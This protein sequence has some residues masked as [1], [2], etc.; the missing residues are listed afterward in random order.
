M[1]KLNNELSREIPDWAIECSLAVD[2]VGVLGTNNVDYFLE[3]ISKPPQLS[4]ELMGQ[5]HHRSS[6]YD[7]SPKVLRSTCVG[8]NCFCLQQRQWNRQIFT[9]VKNNYGQCDWWLKSSASTVS[10]NLQSTKLELAEDE[11]L[12]ICV[13]ENHSF[14]DKVQILDLWSKIICYQTQ[15]EYQTMMWPW[16]SR[17]KEALTSV[18][19]SFNSSL[20]KDTHRIGGGGSCYSCWRFPVCHGGLRSAIVSDTQ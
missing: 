19:R 6:W 11:G 15:R 16:K 8:D 20:P 13:R 1:H 2:V 17:N 9:N 5:F 7:T 10:F 12:R 14:Y 3:F 18:S 4:K